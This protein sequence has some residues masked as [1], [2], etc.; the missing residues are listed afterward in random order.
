MAAGS[1]LC[2]LI[3]DIGGTNA[4]FAWVAEG[5]AG[6]HD[7]KIYQGADYPSLA[8]A[9]K[10]YLSDTA[11]PGAVR[12][13]HFSVAGP[14]T[15]DHFSM[16]NSPWSFSVR[17]LASDI[18]LD[19]LKLWNDFEAVAMAVPFLAPEYLRQCG[20]GAPVPQAPIG[21]L[22]PGTGLGM[23]GLFWQSGRYC[24]VPSEG[25]HA[26]MAAVTRREFDIFQS[27]LGKYTHYSAERVCSGKGLVNLYEVIRSLDGKTALPDLTPAE[28]STKGMAGSCPVCAESMTLMMRFLG[29]VAGN[30][31]L[32]F[33]ARGGIYV[34]GGIVPKLGDYIFNSDFRTEF[35][36]KGRFRP[37]MED[38]PVYIVTHPFPAFVGLT[39]HIRDDMKG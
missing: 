18:G 6:W 20:G 22:G 28:I 13:A 24:A 25:A 39:A 10:A 37:F 16:T 36:S 17:G 34:A 30:L 1:E 12:H 26:T 33:A 14:V 38:I 3:A 19:Q 7:E 31:A 23:A 11:I 2:G 32:T 15:G 8:D 21:V 29:R 5:A 35:E 27:L 4:R 9:V